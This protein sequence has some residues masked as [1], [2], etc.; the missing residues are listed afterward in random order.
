MASAVG[1]AVLQPPV[2]R[3]NQRRVVRNAK[4]QQVTF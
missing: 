3:L 4:A 2:P 1:C